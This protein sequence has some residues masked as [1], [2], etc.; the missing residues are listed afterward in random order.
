VTAAVEDDQLGT[1]MLK[2]KVPG[3]TDPQDKFKRVQL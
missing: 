3:W 1:G 2:V